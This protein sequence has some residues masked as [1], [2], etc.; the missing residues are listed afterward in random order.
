M[1]Q[2]LLSKLETDG[3]CV[4]PNILT[5]DKCDEYIT[6]IW[7]WLENLGTG[8]DRN[9]KSTWNSE[10]WPPNIHGIIQQLRAGQEQFAW[11]IRCEQN[12]IDIFE[13]IWDTDKLLVSFDAI[14][15]MKPPEI[16][17]HYRN[18]SWLHTD[19]SSTKKGRHCIQGLVNLEEAS[20][21]DACLL[22]YK[23]SHKYH[24]ELFEHNGKIVKPDW[25]K[26]NEDDLDWVNTK[27][28]ELTRVAAPKGSVVLWDSRSIHSNTPAKKN[29]HNQRFRYVVY[30]CMTPE[31]LCDKKNKKKKKEAFENLRVTSHWPHHIRLFPKNP[32]T[33]GKILPNYNIRQEHATLSERGKQLA[34]LIEY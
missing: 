6:Q 18:T 24:Q 11:D 20:E 10:K 25:Y 19:Q 1:N 2:T 13:K 23:G 26:L 34:G 29:R 33:F 7:D 27:N 12:V 22:V 30:V 32:Q 15:I 16:S 5:S 14:C 28:M 8:I 9:D 21:D 17:G 31:T 4:V 3:Y